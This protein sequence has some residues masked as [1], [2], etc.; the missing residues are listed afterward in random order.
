MK[1][2][3]MRVDAYPDTGYGHLKR[4]LVIA[5]SLRERGEVVFFLLGGDPPAAREVQKEGFELRQVSRRMSFSN[6]ANTLDPHDFENVSITILDLAH[7]SALKD[8]RGFALYAKEINQR[9]FTVLIDSFGEQS[10]RA[11]VSELVCDV[12]VSPY[13]GE[14]KSKRQTTYTELLGVD[15]FVLDKSYLNYRKKEINELAAKVLIT[16]GGSDPT[17]VSRKILNALKSSVIRRLDI[18]SS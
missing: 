13:I 2:I 15:Y 4:C 3:C 1:K 8:C 10:L 5:D 6:E 14:R 16:C 12:L 17:S 9:T 18:N 7:G 11:N